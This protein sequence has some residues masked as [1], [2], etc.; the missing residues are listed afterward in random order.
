M[1]PGDI[2][3]DGFYVSKTGLFVREIVDEV[4]EY[5]YWRD[6]FLNDGE[7]ISTAAHCCSRRALAR[8]AE[9]ATTPEE[10]ARMQVGEAVAAE[11]ARKTTLIEVVLMTASDAQI[12]EDVRGRGLDVDK[13]AR[14]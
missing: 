14:Q 1:K 5:I 2:E 8:W 9:R 10:V 7:P 11:M 12:L 4:G 6:Y 13:Q 3:R